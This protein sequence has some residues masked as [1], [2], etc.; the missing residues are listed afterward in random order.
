MFAVQKGR[1]EIFDYIYD[2][3]LDKDWQNPAVSQLVEQ[4]Y[5]ALAY[6]R[7]AGAEDAWVL[8][9]DWMI[10][11]PDILSW[12]RTIYWKHNKPRRLRQRQGTLDAALLFERNGPSIDSFYGE[13]RDQGG[14]RPYQVSMASASEGIPAVGTA[15]SSQGGVETIGVASRPASS[16]ES[17]NHSN[18]KDVMLR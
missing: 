7:W 16:G 5:V 1:R 6:E 14:W 4:K 9:G 15:S 2:E 8:D 10:S 13:Q 12:M 17:S 18:W 11:R 3:I